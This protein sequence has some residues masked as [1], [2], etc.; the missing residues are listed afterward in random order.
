MNQQKRNFR[1]LVGLPQSHYVLIAI[2]LSQSSIVSAGEQVENTKNKRSEQI[3]SF[4]TSKPS[5]PPNQIN[6]AKISD[7]NADIRSVDVLP[8]IYVQAPTVSS[9]SESTQNLTLLHAIRIAVDRHPS[10]G[11]EISGLGQQYSNVDVAKSAYW[12]QVQAGIT[13]GRLGTGTAQEQILSV[14]ANQTLYD[15]GKVKNNVN[16]TEASVS[17]Q[18]ANVLGAIDTVALQTAEAVVNVSRY[19][20]L[21]RIAQ[22]QV[23]GINRILNIARLRANAGL[24]SQADPIQAQT[25]YESA[26]STLLQMQ[27]SLS[28]SE[29]RLKSLTGLPRP[30]SLAPFPE[31]LLS[32]AKLYENPQPSS[33]P[34]VIAAE[35][36]QQSALAQKD[37]AR[38]N[39]FPTLSL[40]GSVNRALNGVNP[41][42][43]KE[44]G[45][46]SSVMLKVT[47]ATWQGGGMASRER[48]ANAAVEAAR[49]KK[50]A[51][52]LDASDQIRNYREQVLGTQQRLGVLANREQSIIKTRELYEDQYKL[53]TRTVLDLLN[54]EQEM[55]FAASEKENA[56]FDTWQNL[57]NYI[58]VTG[59][60]RDVYGLNDTSIQ[61]IEIK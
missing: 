59:R 41:N 33:L 58:S 10:I 6:T 31:D 50:E 40:D 48:A 22:A 8:T 45:V 5:Q 15:F 39:R 17:Q 47:S 60:S 37:L 36:E 16:A 29:E 24:T 4:F 43:N 2:L 61:G 28:Q 11:A 18:K 35:Y 7:F 38:S 9:G 51:A 26:Q 56:R 21:V 12:P 23:D 13:T 27:L 25:R 30:Y 32:K 53:G 42:N 14:S 44:N 49:A 52:Y 20:S 1:F 3:K 34:S 54:S 46:Y 19:Q 55:Q 57:V